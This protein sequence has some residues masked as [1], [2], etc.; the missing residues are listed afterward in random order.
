MQLKATSEG[1]LKAFILIYDSQAEVSI[2]IS[3]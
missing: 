2:F 1:N 3:Y